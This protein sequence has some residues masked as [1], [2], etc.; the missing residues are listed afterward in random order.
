MHMVSHSAFKKQKVSFAP[1]NIKI[2]ENVRT[3]QS[4]SKKLWLLKSVYQSSLTLGFYITWK[5]VLPGFFFVMQSHDS[6]EA[7]ITDKPRK[8][9]YILQTAALHLS[10]KVIPTGWTLAQV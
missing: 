5:T 4:K 7:S 1:V 9:F 8:S 6:S 10:E 2:P 3:S